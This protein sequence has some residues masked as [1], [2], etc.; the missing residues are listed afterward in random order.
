MVLKLA[1]VFDEADVAGMLGP[2]LVSKL[3]SLVRL[4]EYDVYFF[5]STSYQGVT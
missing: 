1:E 3:H 4:G 5:T 2:K